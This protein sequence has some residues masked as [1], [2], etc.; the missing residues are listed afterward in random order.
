MVRTLFYFLNF[1]LNDL[2]FLIISLRRIINFFFWS[3]ILCWLSYLMSLYVPFFCT[4]EF[5]T[6]LI[7]Y[8]TNHS[9]F[10]F[11]VMVFL[12]YSCRLYFSIVPLTLMLVFIDRLVWFFFPF[13][14]HFTVYHFSTAVSC[15]SIWRLGRLHLLFINLCIVCCLVFDFWLF[16]SWFCSSWLN[17]SFSF[18]I[19][20]F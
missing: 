18:Q 15:R 19:P 11:T 6:L 2:Y 10:T 3:S 20:P 13:H 5:L 16:Y 7:L 9:P 12:Y 8:W 1:S 14:L 17:G 4:H